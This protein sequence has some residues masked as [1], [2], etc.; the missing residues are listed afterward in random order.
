MSTK[1]YVAYRLRT[2]YLLWPVLRELR[3]KAEANAKK[4]LTKA[5]K[6]YLDLWAQDEAAAEEA[7]KT[8]RYK[9]TRETL[10]FHDAAWYF[11]Q[12][13][14]EQSTS[15]EKNE[16]D[17]DVA[18]SVRYT[19]SRYILVPYPGSGYLSSCLNFMRRHPALEDYH[20]QNASDKPRHI[21]EVRWRER[22]R[23]WDKLLDDGNFGDKLDLVISS[24]A[25]FE[26]VDPSFAMTVR[27]IAKMKN[28]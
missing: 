18:V 5:Y 25:G 19:G 1:I 10:T 21:S 16:F 26:R 9:R 28:R 14:R 20:Y 24:S 6:A 22:A 15:F 11:R 3:R 8:I 4:I 17:L 7:I 23:V 2:G 12:K 13:F 27:A